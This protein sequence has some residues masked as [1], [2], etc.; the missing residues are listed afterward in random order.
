MVKRYLVVST[1][2]SASTHLKALAIFALKAD[3]NNRSTHFPK[4]IVDG[5]MKLELGGYVRFRS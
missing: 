2:A 4:K 5:D 1:P 3:Q